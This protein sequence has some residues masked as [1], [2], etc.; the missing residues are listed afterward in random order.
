MEYNRAFHRATA[1]AAMTTADVIVP[2]LQRLVS[3]CSVVDVGC[4]LGAWLA[5]W[6]AVGVEDILGLDLRVN[7]EDLLIDPSQFREIDIG[8]PFDVGRKFDLAM[9]L[10]VGEHLDPESAPALVESLVRLAPVVAFS[11][12]IPFQGGTDHRN[13]QWPDYWEGLFDRN[14]YVAI[15]CL[16]LPYWDDQRVAW[17]YAQNSV[18]YVEKGRLS[19]YRLPHRDVAGPVPRL[20]HPIN[21]LA[22]ADPASQGVRAATRA[23]LSAVVRAASRLRRRQRR[24]ELTG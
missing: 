16:R 6:R 10:E 11:A 20:V 1:G 18:L 2:A 9:C 17:W 7:Q 3:P 4:G 12:A 19:A 22:A 13:E 14:G 23:L 8:R 15:D 24:Q 21:Y 5:K